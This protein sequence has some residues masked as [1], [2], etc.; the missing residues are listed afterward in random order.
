[1]GLNVGVYVK[2]DIL[3]LR[4]KGELDDVTVND[5]RKRISDYIDGYRI[6]HLVINF[7]NLDFIDSSGI[8]FIIGRYHQ[9]K[10]R[11]G[12]ITLCNIPSKLE[13]II[14]I[15]GL[16]KICC[17]R[18]SEEALLLSMGEKING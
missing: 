2:G 1:M 12:D 13:R 8:G 5:L 16:Y 15:S 6:K 4:L 9:I 17:I 11:N 3:I 7:L 18:E 14:S 10:K